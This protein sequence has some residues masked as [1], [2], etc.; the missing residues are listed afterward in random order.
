[1]RQRT[2]DKFELHHCCN[3]H[4]TCYAACGI[5]FEYC[6][7]AFKK[8]MAVRRTAAPS[9]RALL[10]HRVLPLPAEDKWK[11]TAPSCRS[12]LVFCSRLSSLSSPNFSGD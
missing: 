9:C 4:D 12:H 1:M 3:A 7:Q 6:E 5:E 10:P 11:K 2:G 8:C